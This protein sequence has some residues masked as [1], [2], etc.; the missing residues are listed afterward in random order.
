MNCEIRVFEKSRAH[1]RDRRGG[2][3]QGD[4]HHLEEQS[5]S[6][7]PGRKN[8][9]AHY[10]KTAKTSKGCEKSGEDRHRGSRIENARRKVLQRGEREERKAL[11]HRE[12]RERG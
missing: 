2:P 9:E 4:M 6:P 3:E 11:P 1:K 5:R 10:W 7:R 8:G 12:Q